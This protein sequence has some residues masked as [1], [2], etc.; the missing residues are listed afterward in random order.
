[1]FRED[2]VEQ[3]VIEQLKELGY[4]YQYAPDIERDYKEAI[5]KDVFYESL[6]KINKGIT[7]D[8]ADEV[9][10]KIRNFHAV[11][12]VEANYEFYHMLYAG[13]EVPIEGDKTF[14]AKLIDRE[15][16]EHN[17]FQ[18]LNQY[19]VIEYKEKRPDVVVF[20]NGIPL[21][22]FEL[23][24]AINEDT[25]IENAYNQ[26]KNYQEDIKSLFYYNA[27]SVIS[28]GI[29][30]R[31]GTITADFNRFMT[32]KSKDGE[33]PEDNINQIDVLLNGVF[34]KDRL[35]D[36]ITNFILFQ[37]KEKGRIKILAG[38]HQY[39]AVDKS[40]KS[41]L[42][43]LDEHTGKAGVV[44]HTQGSGKSFAMVF[45]TG[46]ISKIQSL[47]NPTI[48]V[49]TDR[50]DLDNQLYE[51]FA[52]TNREILPQK[53]Q[54]AASRKKLKELLSVNA[55]GIIFTTIQKFEEGDDIISDREN[56]IFIVDEAHRSQY[57]TEKKFN[58][59]TGEFQTG[60][61]KKMRDSLPKATFI[62]FTGTPIEYADKNTRILFG[63]YIDVYDMTQAVLD[64]ATVPIYY[65][66]RV[67]KLKLDE[68][69]LK[70][71]DDEY[72]Y[73]IENDEAD[74]ETVTKSKEELAKLE[75]VIG[76][77]DRLEMLSKDIIEHYEQREDILNGKAMIVC[78][79]RKI[80]IDL[81][82]EIIEKRPEWKDKIKV[83]L[84]DNNDDPTNWHEIVGN[85]KYR[86]DLATEFKDEKSKLKIVI[87][88]DMWLTGFDVPDL[89]TMYI[90]KPMR[91]HNLMQAIARVNRVYKDKEAGLIVDYIG[92][93]A[94]LRNA[95]NEYT[96]RDRDK[97][98]DITAAYVIVREK[99]EV[100]RDF[101]YG[102]DYQGFF[103]SSNQLRLR[104]LADGINYVLS[105]DED[106]KK[107]FIA[108]ATALSQAETLARSILDEQTKLEVEFFKG[109]KVGVNKI[110]GKGHLTTTEVNQR[111]LNVLE[112]AIQEDGIIDIFKAA[113]R[114][115]PE[116]SILSEEYLESIKKSK[117]K[118]IAAELLKRLIDGN[119][120]V[121]KRTNLVKA[122]L[123]SQKM[124][125]IMKKYNNR[126][127]TSA[128]VIEEL[129]N[130]SKEVVDAKNEGK[131]KGLTDDEYAF[132][133]ALVKDPNVLKEMQD[134]VLIQLAHEL[135]ETVR[136]NRT[137]DWDK[138]ESAR[139]F[140]R[141]EIKRLLRKYHYPPTKA[142]EAVQTVVLQAELMGENIEVSKKRDDDT[143][144]E[145]I[146]VK[147]TGFRNEEEL[148][149][150][151]N[152]NAEIL[153]VAEE[154]EKYDPFES[155][156]GKFKTES[157]R[158]IYYYGEE[159]GEM[160]VVNK[161]YEGINTL[162]D[163]FGILLKAWSKES[164]YPSAQEDPEY[165]KVN[166]PTYGQCAITATIVHDLFGG[167]IHRIR[168]NG[169]GTHYFNK[170]NGHYIDLTRDQFD[171]YNIPI[172]Y[173]PNE[174]IDREYC[175]KN[176]DTL[177]R[178]NKLIENL[179]RIINL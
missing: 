82:K 63:D 75:T 79:T 135:T 78:M 141:R 100:M 169:G 43:A 5:L 113:D 146:N 23:K 99:L 50:N 74:V 53:T 4:E 42:K 14:V 142:D 24:N 121:F 166:D 31:I 136:K 104:T 18:V 94:D 13:V 152:N 168:V 137:V 114:S 91:G 112:Q 29:N 140:M 67:A 62:A 154:E 41:T 95:L 19:T 97:V 2:N 96:N 86:D 148:Y 81:Y 111:I 179:A 118:N 28:D 25:T 89:A 153:K 12:L 32:W 45:Y 10:R 37:N 145:H 164:A 80:A 65:E 40:I 158:N 93:G 144:T 178:Y 160:P 115:N 11:D 47:N 69:V 150:L 46:K 172:N 117:N 49:L 165:N 103:S 72:K 1:M 27:F 110:T 20:I 125:E 105:K 17:L 108:E 157:G 8:I 15:N 123:F 26:I 163:L 88:V 73:I 44:W 7:E 57:S 70:E 56:I 64:N 177:K 167:T 124:T 155:N 90:D 68:N 116:I 71:I 84:T 21:I 128:E 122:E 173:E 119:I 38:Y 35:I 162:N 60:Y 131:E 151:V 16:I 127:I 52:N 83:V 61:A 156:K 87:V 92:I 133:D 66:N 101:F 36:I 39:F 85:K 22:V 6:Y 130:L 77:Q 147:T 143:Q 58:R 33:K 120:R 126:L 30:A 174:T 54:H 109:V 129:L 107:D 139:A 175:N 34:R 138:K 98:P 76:A 170:I 102:F 176:Q 48:V 132:Y 171:I 149:N 134:E 159:F 51:T 9:Y 55:G 106:E 161:K 3:A 59:K